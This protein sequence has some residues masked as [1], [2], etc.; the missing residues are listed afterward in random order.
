MAFAIL[1]AG[2]AS[3]TSPTRTPAPPSTRTPPAPAGA[4]GSPASRS[5]SA[6]ET[7]WHQSVTNDD[8]RQALQKA[9]LQA[10]IQP[11]IAKI[12]G[13]TN[14][15]SLTILNGRWAQYWSKDGG[16]LGINDDGAYTIDGDQVTSTHDDGCN[17]NYRWSLQADTLA[18]TFLSSGC[19]PTDGIPENVYQTAFYMSAPW[20]R[21]APR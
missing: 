3:G 4:I 21:G 19:A 18:I 12:A 13:T 8:M 7:V 6:L 9:G 15:F 10:W 20:M 11:F 14:L 17:D 5:P 1:L 16:I 2:C